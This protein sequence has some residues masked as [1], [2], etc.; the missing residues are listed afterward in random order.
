MPL[1]RANVLRQRDVDGIEDGNEEGNRSDNMS[2][3]QYNWNASEVLQ[4]ADTSL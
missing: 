3:Y 2:R 4:I 1:L